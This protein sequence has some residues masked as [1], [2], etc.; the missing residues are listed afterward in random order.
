MKTTFS[1]LLVLISLAI[2]AQGVIP[3]PDRNLFRD[4]PY[5]FSIYL[6]KA[7]S[8]RSA[9]ATLYTRQKGLPVEPVNQPQVVKSGR[10]VVIG[11]PNTSSLPDRAWLEIKLD[12]VTRYTAWVNTSKNSPQTATPG[13]LT[14]SDPSQPVATPVVPTVSAK[15]YRVASVSPSNYFITHDKGIHLVTANFFR[16]DNGQ[17]DSVWRIVVVND[18]AVQVTGPPG[19]LFTGTIVLTFISQLS[20]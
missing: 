1:I 13:S 12:N 14:V 2:H 19:E 15:A 17:L 8:L 20:N 5:S 11:W 16:E 9:S 7:D 18:N 3:L 6:I 4:V 10:T